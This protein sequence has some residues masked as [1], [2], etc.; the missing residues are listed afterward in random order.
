MARLTDIRKS[1]RSEMVELSKTDSFSNV[2]IYHEGDI[3]PPNYDE[4]R[5]SS[6][7]MRVLVEPTEKGDE[8]M[9]GAFQ[10]L[11]NLTFEIGSPREAAE[12]RDELAD[13]LEDRFTASNI[14]ELVVDCLKSREEAEQTQTRTWYSTMLTFDAWWD[15]NA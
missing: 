10:Q 14:G 2:I 12:K 9:G 13:A 8:Y 7:W 11:A 4:Q 1:V 15:Y 5:R 6:V 3:A